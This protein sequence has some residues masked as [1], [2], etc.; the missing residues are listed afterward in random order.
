MLNDLKILFVEDDPD[1]RDIMG[2][3]FTELTDSFTMADDGLTGFEL[4][5]KINPHIVITDINMPKLNGIEMAR[6]I[7]EISKDTPIIL[8]SAFNDFKYLNQSVDLGIDKYLIK[9][10]DISKLI[11]TLMDIRERFRDDRQ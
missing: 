7:K 6:K 10:I 8:V 5:K 4:F 2:E 11:S 9:P 1:I 3:Y